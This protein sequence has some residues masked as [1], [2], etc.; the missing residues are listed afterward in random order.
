MPPAPMP[1]PDIW[2]TNPHA[3][4][5]LGNIILLFCLLVLY[6]KNYEQIK[7]KFALGLIAFVIL[8]LVQA[9]TS[10]PIAHFLW[11]FRSIYALGLLTLVSAWFEF[12]ALAIL[13]YISLRPE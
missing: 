10:H 1:P 11:G 12:V 6:V 9:F 4:I 8:L 7:S 13:L 2:L 5:T 3:L